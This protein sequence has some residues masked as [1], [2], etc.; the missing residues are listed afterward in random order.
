MGLGIR[1]RLLN[2][3]LP[4]PATADN[5]QY[6][7]IFSAHDDKSFA[8]E[9]LL[10]LSLSAAKLASQISLKHISSRMQC[11]PYYPDVWPG[12][13]YKLLSALVRIMAP[14]L[15]IEIGT[16]TG[17]SALA[18]RD[19][20][21]AD[22]RLI[23]FDIVPWNSLHDTVLVESDFTD[24]KLIQ[25]TDDVTN[26][27]GYNALSG[28]FEQAELI[29]I[30]AAKDFEMERRIVR[31]LSQTKFER[32]PIV[33]FDDIRLWPMLKLWRDIDRPKLDLTSFGHWSGTGLIDWS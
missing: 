23:T 3:L 1:S 5:A 28:L 16:Y 10:E 18:M 7:M 8:N 9:R 32:S 29:F 24:G 21:P 11:A 20:L 25:Y 4:H 19:A 15:V 26:A 14:K 30:D 33:V 22:G 17:L 12:E 27:E 6:S 2:K 13:H 31:L